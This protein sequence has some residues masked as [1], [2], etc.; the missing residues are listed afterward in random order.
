MLELNTANDKFYSPI[1]ID[2][3]GLVHLQLHSVQSSYRYESILRIG[4]VLGHRIDA[5]IS[6]KAASE[7]VQTAVSENR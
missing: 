4:V 2:R 7:K 1:Y 5:E 3:I 6:P